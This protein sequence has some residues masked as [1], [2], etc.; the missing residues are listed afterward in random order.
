MDYL[1]DAAELENFKNAETYSD[2]AR[3]VYLYRD[4][5]RNKTEGMK[6][7]QKA[8]AIDKNCANAWLNKGNF[9]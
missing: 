5:E 1:E 7:V 3:C 6:L 4:K 2:M 8:L 9:E